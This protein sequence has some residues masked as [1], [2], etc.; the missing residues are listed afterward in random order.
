M[1]L[2]ENVKNLKSTSLF[3]KE[4]KNPKSA[5]AL[6][7]EEEHLHPHASSETKGYTPFARGGNPENRNGSPRMD[8]LNFPKN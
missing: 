7:S 5:D 3:L 4:D 6:V 8:W 2:H 1:L